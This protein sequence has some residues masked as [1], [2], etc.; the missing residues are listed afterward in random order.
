M[1]IYTERVKRSS[2][3]QIDHNLKTLEKGLV[4]AK[5]NGTYDG[6]TPEII[7]SKI[8]VNNRVLDEICN[9]AWEEIQQLKRDGKWDCD[10]Q[11]NEEEG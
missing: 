6:D 3:K 8:D 10:E 5:E 7:Q 1:G 2:I 4:H 11:P 9:A